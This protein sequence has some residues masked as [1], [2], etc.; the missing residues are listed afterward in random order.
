MARTVRFTTLEDAFYFLNQVRGLPPV[1]STLSLRGRFVRAGIILSWVALEEV[2]NSVVEERGYD[3]LKDFPNPPKLMAVI[4]YAARKNKQ[5]IK[6]TDL[7]K[8]RELRNQV[9]H[10]RSDAVQNAALTES[11]CRFVFDCCLAAARAVS[12]F[13]LECKI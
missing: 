9:T 2:V 7:L 1:P 8:A 5:T 6:I 12:P 10:F 13:R 4:Q 11:N 3:S